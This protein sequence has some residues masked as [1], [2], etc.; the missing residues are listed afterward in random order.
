MKT[1]EDLL[2]AVVPF[3]IKQSVAQPRHYGTYVQARAAILSEFQDDLGEMTLSQKAAAIVSCPFAD[4]VADDDI[5][6]SVT[7]LD[8]A[9]SQALLQMLMRASAP[10]LR[11][12]VGRIYGEGLAGRVFMLGRAASLATE[13]ASGPQRVMASRLDEIMKNEVSPSRSLPADFRRAVMQAKAAVVRAEPEGDERIEILTG[14]HRRERMALAL[15]A[16]DVV[17]MLDDVG[18]WPD[19]VWELLIVGTDDARR[20]VTLER[21]GD[22]V[23]IEAEA[24]H[25]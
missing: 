4:E 21:R 6:G 12:I 5:A 11:E 25:V 10:A 19:V 16:D 22:V 14:L 24:N 2:A 13:A 20:N 18:V 15:A 3:V 7:D 9:V 1:F 17:A 23:R 8:D